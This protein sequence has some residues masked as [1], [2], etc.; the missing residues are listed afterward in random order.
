[1]EV[2][3][4]FPNG[5]SVDDAFDLVGPLAVYIVG[6]AVYA[7]FIFKFY[8]F[9]AS[10]DMFKLDF[11]KYEASRFKFVRTVL[12]FVFYVLQYLILFPFFAFFWFAVLTV[13]L[14]FLSK[15]KDFADVLLVAL[16]TVGAVRVASYYN[17][18]LS[19][20]LAKILPFAVLAIFLIDVSF[21]KI[22]DSL[23]VLKQADDHRER[24]LYYLIALIALEFALRLAMA[25]I[26]VFCVVR[27]RIRMVPEPPEH[28]EPSSAGEEPVA[29]E[30]P[31]QDESPRHDDATQDEAPEHA[32]DTGASEH[33][34]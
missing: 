4:L 21:F 24:I 30:Y 5:L 34:E 22:N 16:A 7:I 28:Y 23:E 15:E 19:R 1:M 13:L 31:R 17:E 2:N 6:M 25:A 11:S 29:E 9:L 12:H 3:D 26:T 14:A 33:N 10:R 18:D 20:D 8:R 27:D 32:P